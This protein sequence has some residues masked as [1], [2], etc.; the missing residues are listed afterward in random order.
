MLRG[1]R[2]A[3]GIP[4]L[5][6]VTLGVGMALVTIQYAALH[7]LLF[8]SLPF[9]PT[10]RLVSVR[11]SAPA[12]RSQEARPRLPELRALGRAQ[13]TLESLTG[14]SVGHIGH[15]VRLPNGQWIQREGLAVL[16]QLLET[17]GL[18]VH[19]GRA[20]L[21]EDFAPGAAP[22]L[23]LSRRL[24][25]ELGGDPKIVGTSLHFDRRPHTIV[26]VAD[27][28][29]TI[30]GETFW[31]PSTESP[32]AREA[33]GPIEALASLR[34]GVTVRQASEDVARL[35]V[36]ELAMTPLLLSRLGHLEVVAAREGLVEPKVTQF[37]VM[38]L[39]SVLL[40]L[41]CA[42]AN[43]SN[44][45]LARA[46]GRVPELALRACL[47][48][49]RGRLVRQLL[50]EALAIGGVAA[51]LGLGVAILLSAQARAQGQVM[52]LPSWV[53]GD[54]DLTIAGVVTL[55]SLAAAMTAALVP[56]LRA[57]RLDLHALLKDD[58]RTASGVSTTRTVSWL[59]CAQIAVSTGVLLVAC[60]VGLTVHQRAVRSLRVDPRA[61]LG[62][63]LVFP[64]DEFRTEEQARAVAL[65][66]DRALRDL[67][68]GMRGG[69]SSRAGLGPGR[70]VPVRTSTAEPGQRAHQVQAG[71]SY[72]AALGA[73][74]LEGRPFDDGDSSDAPRVAIVDTAF[75]DA[76][77]RG[78]SSVG[79]RLLV[80]VAP[81]QEVE[82]RV[83]GVVS[84]LHLGGAASVRPDAPGFFTPLAQME[85]RTAVF[86]FVTGAPGSAL[87]KTLAA[88]V[89][90]AD[91][92]RPPRRMRTFQAELDAQQSGLRVFLQLFGGFGLAAL[93]L[94]ATG[95][96]GLFAL[97]VRQ[98][99]REI[100]TRMALGATAGGILALFLRRSA[101]HLAVGVMVGGTLGVV[102]LGS[103]EKKLGPLVGALPAFL[104]TAA[105]LGSVGLVATVVPAVRGARLS[106]MAALR[107]G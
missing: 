24:W 5:S 23:I 70:E 101:A 80:Q 88:I 1:L 30:E 14:F 51:A 91:P 8:R 84:S 29:P 95:L 68:G 38:M 82:M 57:S 46:A 37:Y 90:A 25:R 73:S 3:P 22:V 55:L 19:L 44:L 58:A 43:V 86:P 2:R 87:E 72:F 7:Q 34:P 65:A 77:W 53:T 42:C 62:T 21:A 100:G 32:A 15:S 67:P 52:P 97:A 93:A 103:I 71:L 9:D 94:S 40:V 74:M 76:F 105:V 35:G 16:P 104:L 98:R 39:G 36:T 61:Y 75:A 81:D 6:A 99:V 4:I 107:D 17:I 41:F 20:F 106:P 10:G 26:G 64:R 63:A 11:W 54:L 79:R 49:T 47:G 69:V 45:L 89:R 13:G 60:S 33:G 18:R 96:Y 85:R 83:V 48:A 102:L 78:Q 56:A 12:P 31:A 50:V 92:E 66:L 28:G 27:E 59:Q